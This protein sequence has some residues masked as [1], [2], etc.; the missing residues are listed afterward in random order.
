MLIIY[1]KKIIPITM[2]LSLLLT[3]TLQLNFILKKCEK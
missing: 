3:V 2:Y 1:G